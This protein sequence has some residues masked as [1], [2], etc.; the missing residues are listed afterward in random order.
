MDRDDRDGRKL[1]FSPSFGR[2]QRCDEVRVCVHFRLLVASPIAGP[3]GTLCDR[4][5]GRRPA[6]GKVSE[7]E[8]FPHHERS[9]TVHSSGQPTVTVPVTGR[10]GSGAMENWHGMQVRPSTR[11]KLGTPSSDSFQS[12]LHRSDVVVGEKK[13]KAFQETASPGY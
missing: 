6:K 7:I 4:K 1:I 2:H 8:S 9:D 11:L 10:S 5:T 13:L 3:L 12:P